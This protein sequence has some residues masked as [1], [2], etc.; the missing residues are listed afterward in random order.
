MINGTLKSDQLVLGKLTIDWLRQVPQITVLAA[1]INS[2]NGQ[3]HA[4]L[5]GT[6]VQ[7]SEKTARAL[8]ALRL[9]LEE[10]LAAI[11]M[12]DV[13][14]SVTGMAEKEAGLRVP[15]GGL[16]EHLGTRDDTPSA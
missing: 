9:S 12:I 3:T 15:V 10:D 6:G 5:D 2:K 1:C 13:S 4:W 7:W 14:S 8:E 11:H 16:A